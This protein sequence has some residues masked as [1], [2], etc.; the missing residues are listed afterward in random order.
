MVLRGLRRMS[1]HPRLRRIIT[2]RNCHENLPLKSLQILERR[3]GPSTGCVQ[4]A[5]RLVGRVNPG[6]FSLTRGSPDRSA[7]GATN[8]AAR[9]EALQGAT[10]DTGYPFLYPSIY[11]SH[12]KEPLE[13]PVNESNW[14]TATGIAVCMGNYSS[15]DP[16]RCLLHAVRS[17]RLF[18]LEY[19][20]MTLLKISKTYPEWGRRLFPRLSGES[21][22]DLLD[23][24]ERRRIDPPGIRIC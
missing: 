17:R 24:S 3:G 22:L 23:K 7:G 5:P 10:S 6:R 4:E 14:A 19:V 15:W 1:I 11:P 16:L 20:I 21:P 8:R 18:A 12:A 2:S 13:R 9:Q